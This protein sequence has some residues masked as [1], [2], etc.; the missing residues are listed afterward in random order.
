MYIKN[1]HISPLSDNP[2]ELKPTLLG[3]NSYPPLLSTLVDAEKAKP[4]YKVRQ[5]DQIVGQIFQATDSYIS[6]VLLKL[7]FIGNGGSGLWKIQ[8]KE[9]ERRGD[10]YLIKD[11]ILAESKFNPEVDLERYSRG[12]D[13]YKFSLP[14][15]IEPGKY[16]FVEI[17]ALEVRLS[18]FNYLA[19]FGYKNDVITESVALSGNG[20]NLAYR[21]DLLFQI[22][23]AKFTDYQNKRIPSGAVIED[24]GEGV[25]RYTLER[26]GNFSDY[27]NIDSINGANVSDSNVFYQSLDELIEARAAGENNFVYRIDTIY[28]FT[29]LRFELS[30][31][32]KDYY[33]TIVNYSF[34]GQNWHS[35]AK[36]KN[37]NSYN[38]L[39]TG[40]GGSQIYFQFSYDPEYKEA[41]KP[42]FGLSNFKI[43]ADLKI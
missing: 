31:L 14:A 17:N 42:V 22:Y 12:N 30:N 9:A 36:D 11:Q 8:L 15:M 34:D 2:N 7:N 3:R 28:P 25:G 33:P 4:I 6:A 1:I 13:Y 5:K 41:T 29:K 10:Q 27:L 23:G 39:I 37:Y 24:L 35:L 40:E 16:Y 19:V 32:G 38:T 26:Q 43:T 21:G 20:E 18:L